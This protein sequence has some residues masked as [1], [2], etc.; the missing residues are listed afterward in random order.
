MSSKPQYCAHSRQLLLFCCQT[1]ESL[2]KHFRELL[3]QQNLSQVFLG[4]QVVQLADHIL[5]EDSYH[6]V[7]VAA[8]RIVRIDRTDLVGHTGFLV[9]VQGTGRIGCR[10]VDSKDIVAV[11]VLDSIAPKRLVES[12]RGILAYAAEEGSGHVVL[13]AVSV[14]PLDVAPG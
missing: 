11:A 10:L 6:I 3:V 5:A 8:G 9:P 2:A 13:L 4:S 14:A 1:L 12:A 7:E